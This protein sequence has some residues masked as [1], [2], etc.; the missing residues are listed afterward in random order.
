MTPSPGQKDTD[1]LPPYELL[2]EVLK[3]LIEGARLPQWERTQSLAVV[4]KLQADP[5]GQQLL[6]RIQKMIARNEYKRRQAPPVL[7]VRGL[8]FGNG[9]QVPIAAVQY[10]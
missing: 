8:A 4:E 9:R 7:R 3:H 6:M 2:D 1:S 10:A 5:A